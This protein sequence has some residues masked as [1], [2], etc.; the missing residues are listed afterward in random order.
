MQI[1]T[2]SSVRFPGDWEINFIGN[3]WNFRIGRSQIALWKNYEPIF[4]W[5][6]I[7]TKENV[8]V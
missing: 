3:V 5:L 8:N 2:F 1:K 7:S 4:N 6:F